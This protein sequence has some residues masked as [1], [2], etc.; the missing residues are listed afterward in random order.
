MRGQHHPLHPTTR[1]AL[2]DLRRA[3]GKAIVLLNRRGWSNFLSC[4]SCGEVWMCPNCEVALVL[5]RATGLSPATTAAIASGCRAAAA[6][7]SS[8]ALARHGAGT[9]RIERELAEAL[10]DAVFPV[11]R[12]DADSSGLEQRARTLERFG[13][14]RAGRARR[15]ADGRQGPRLPR[16]RRSGSCSTPTRRCASPTSA[17]RSER[18]RW[19]PSSPAGRA[20]ARPAG[21]VLVQTL[22][23][24]RARS[25][26]PRGTTPTASSP[27]SCPAARSL[28]YP[29][30]ASL[31]RIV[32]SASDPGDAH[33]RSRPP[34]TGGSRRR[35]P[36]CS[37][38]RR[39][40]ACADALAARSSSRRPTARA[41]IAAVRGGG[42]RDRPRG[43]QARCQRQRRRRSAMTRQTETDDVDTRLKPWPNTHQS[44][45]KSS[46]RRPSR[47]PRPSSIPRSRRGGRR[48][49]R[50]CA[51]SAIRC[52]RRRRGRS[53]GSTTRFARRSH[54]WA[55]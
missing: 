2:A 48:R 1:M 13:A 34:C 12:L 32:C 7:C 29:P 6:S 28:R 45:S 20:A 30:F 26:S 51:S 24:T 47:T 10:G 21:R 25:S 43:L 36:P 14:A 38:R 39:C 23:P 50:T 16:R 40:S 18:S 52:C 54:G 5:H 37:A 27:T 46:R 55:S 8:V 49:S 41:A 3:G 42:R 33:G 35:T 4:R 22:A 9:E 15:N 11:L 17:P 31:I 53:S 19:S 44:S